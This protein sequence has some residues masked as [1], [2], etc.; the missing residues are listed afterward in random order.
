MAVGENGVVG[1]VKSSDLN[2]SSFSSP[3]EVIAH[4]EALLKAG[5]YESI[6][7]YESDGKL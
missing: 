3:E 7:L 6:P 1:Y 2:G 5:G 4:Q